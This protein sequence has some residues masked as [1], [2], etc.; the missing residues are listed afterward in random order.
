MYLNILL[1]ILCFLRFKTIF[2]LDTESFES[3]SDIACEPGKPLSLS[4]C[5]KI[6]YE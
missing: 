6:S 3:E 4:S 2:E 1:F 5:G